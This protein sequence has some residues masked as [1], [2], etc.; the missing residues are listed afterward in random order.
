MYSVRLEQKLLN[1]K[2]PRV[3]VL[4]LVLVLSVFFSGW[5]VYH[6][7]NKASALVYSRLNA[8]DDDP[9]NVAIP[10]KTQAMALSDIGGSKDFT[11]PPIVDGKAPVLSSIPTKQPVVFLGIDDGVTKLPNDLQLM[12]T[13]SV[14]ASLFL[15]ERFIKDDPQ[16]FSQFVSG[17]SFIENHT[18]DHKL[19]SNLTLEQQKQEICGEADI[20]LQEFGRRPVL[21]RPPGGNYNDDTRIA[22]VA[23]GMKAIILWDAK[24]NGGSMQYQGT[25]VLHPGDIV[26]MHFR[27]EFPADFQAFIKAQNS[28]GL[29]TELLEDWL[30]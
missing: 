26:L 6:T 11:L 19:L 29:H 17:G 7:I 4:L 10:Y 16:F 18:L 23:C 9:I 3:G 13:N 8:L 27:K 14:K 21:F 20:Q 1:K 28:A 30:N 5:G 22:A 25:H 12:Q 24:A 15:T 2:L